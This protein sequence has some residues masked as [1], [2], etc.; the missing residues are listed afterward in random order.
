MSTI[1]PFALILPAMADGSP[2]VT[3]F[4]V[5]DE[6]LGCANVTL[7]C[8]PTLK[9]VQS[10]AARLLDCEMLVDVAVVLIEAEPA[11]TWPPVGRAFGAGCARAGWMAT[12]TASTTP[13]TA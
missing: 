12:G 5:T 10:I 2:E 3:R 8:E 6:A 9:V 13:T 4:S 7:C 1:W 11:T